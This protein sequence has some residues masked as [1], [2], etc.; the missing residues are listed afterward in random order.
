MPLH[1]V[2]NGVDIVSCGECSEPHL[3]TN[4]VMRTVWLTTF[5]T[6]YRKSIWIPALLIFLLEMGCATK[7]DKESVSVSSSQ[8]APSQEL[9]KAATLTNTDRK[10][11]AIQALEKAVSSKPN[12]PAYNQLGILYRES[13]RFTDARGAYAAALKVNPDYALAHRNLGILLDIYL[14]QPQ[15]ALVHYR[16]Y[17]KLSGGQDAEAT[18]WVVEMQ[19]RLGVK[20]ES[21]EVTP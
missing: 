8:S 1:K 7:I 21:I 17:E 4:R 2:T 14:Q 3:Y 12:A 11:E 20:A 6:V 9:H 16:A 5:T 10:A 18:L 19:Q 13:G 15:Q